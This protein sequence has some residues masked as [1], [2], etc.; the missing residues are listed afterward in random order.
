[1]RLFLLSPFLAPLFPS[2]TFRDSFSLFYFSWFLS[3]NF[4][5]GYSALEFSYGSSPLISCG[6]SV[7]PSLFPR[8][9]SPFPLSIYG[10]SSSPTTFRWYQHFNLVH[11]FLH[12]FA[13]NIHSLLVLWIVNFSEHLML[14]SMTG[15]PEIEMNV[16][17]H[18][19]LQRA[20]DQ[21]KHGRCFS[22]DKL[23]TAR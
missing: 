12:S 6:Y 16:H 5:F 20:T 11:D 13:I 21:F 2:A 7:H 4:P 10:F 18:D 15:V 3:R 14:S 1:M 8:C 17:P 19:K 9:F 23:Y 22:G